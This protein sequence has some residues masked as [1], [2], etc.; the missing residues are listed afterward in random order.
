MRVTFHPSH[1]SNNFD[2]RVFGNTAPKYR[3]LQLKNTTQDAWS[4]T[5]NYPLPS[6]PRA[7]Y[8]RE[9]FIKGAITQMGHPVPKDRWVHLFINGIYWE[10]YLLSERVDASFMQILDGSQPA[11]LNRIANYDVMTATDPSGQ[12]GIGGAYGV[13][14]GVDTDFQLLRTEC[15]AL[16]KAPTA[17][18]KDALYAT[19]KGHFDVTSESARWGYMSTNGLPAYTRDAGLSAAATNGDWISATRYIRDTWLVDRR[20]T[21]LNAM[22]NAGLYTP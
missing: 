4:V 10:P 6:E 19:I 22:Q 5:Q 13:V 15:L 1:G 12:P 21:Y 2:F 17:A 3:A 14:S 16:K 7:T 11:P 18:A 20:S 9:A 8:T